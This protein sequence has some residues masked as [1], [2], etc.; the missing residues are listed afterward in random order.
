MTITTNGH[1]VQTGCVLDG[2][3][4]WHNHA[5]MIGVATDLGYELDD[6]AQ[7]L[8]DRYDA[9]DSDYESGDPEIVASIM[10]DAERWLNDHTT[11]GYLWHWQDGEFFLSPYCGGDEDC[12]DDECVCHA[13]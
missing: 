5:R 9:G 12:D 8:V 11:D 13:W 10:D 1:P 3:W 7:A 6:D 4:G 2:H